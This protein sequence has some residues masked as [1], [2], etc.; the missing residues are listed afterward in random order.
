VPNHRFVQLE[1]GDFM[2]RPSRVNVDIKGAPGAVE[3]VQM[4]GP[5]T[6]DARG[7]LIF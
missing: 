7:E 2:N 3:Q 5:S 6:V 1:Q 4:G